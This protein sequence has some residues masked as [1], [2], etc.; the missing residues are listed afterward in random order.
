MRMGLIA[1][2]HGNLVALDAVLA[3]LARD[4]LDRLVC[5][6]DVAALGPQPAEVIARLRTL[7]C[8]SL[9]GNTDNWLLSGT[10]AHLASTPFATIT[11]WCAARLTE[12]DWAY[13]RACPRT[14]SVDLAG[15]QQLLCCHGSPRSYDDVIAATTPDMDLDTMLAGYPATIIAGGHTHIQL[16]RQ[17]GATRVINPGSVGL[18]GIGPGDPRLPVNQQVCWAEYALLT[19]DP[20]HVSIDLRRLPLDPAQLDAALLNSAMPDA[21]WW[22]NLWSLGTSPAD[23]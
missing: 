11:S 14:L 4:Q 3:D 21:D 18:P 5:L 17:H 16:L 9:L 8:P 10:P 23:T 12:A 2:I 13:L 20:G 7:D 15:G 1:D 19:L 22:R 6:G